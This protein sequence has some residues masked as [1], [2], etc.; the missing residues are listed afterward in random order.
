MS[1]DVAGAKR[2][3]ESHVG[4][5]LGMKLFGLE[6][7]ESLRLEKSYRA[8]KRELNTEITLQN[9]NNFGHAIAVIFELFL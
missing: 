8:I 5:P 2:A 3:V 1:L 4:E 6:A 9:V 7:L